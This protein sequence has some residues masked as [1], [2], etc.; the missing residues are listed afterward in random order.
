[1]KQYIPG[2]SMIAYMSNLV[3]LHGGINLAQGV[4]GFDPPEKL[5]TLLKETINKPLHQYA[6]GDGNPR[7][8]DAV[9]GLYKNEISLSRKNILI[10]QGA[11]EAITLVYTW[12]NKKFGPDIAVMAMDPLYESFTQLP[13]IFNH[14]LITASFNKRG[15]INWGETEQKLQQS[16]V[17]LFFLNSPGNPWGRVWSREEVKK[18]IT[19]AEQHDFYILSDSVYS[20]LYFNNEPPY[21]P[22]QD[23]HRRV[24]VVNSFSKMLS[25]TGWRIGFLI[26]DPEP[27]EEIKRIHDY[28]GLCANSFIQEAV[29]A[30]LLENDNGRIYRKHLRKQ[31]KKSCD[32]LSKSLN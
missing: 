11:T 12:I 4:P 3:K 16:P 13:D 22:V 19:L 21:V 31:M 6:P 30:Y 2:V 8:M 10:T 24:F 32:F 27:C 29:A 1:M 7:L 26:A 28:T 15:E 25:I 14:Q 23:I 9:I 18:L 17:R 5:V 20:D